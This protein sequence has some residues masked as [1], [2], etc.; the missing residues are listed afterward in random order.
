MAH[1]YRN[2]NQALE[3]SGQCYS[4]CLARKA[5][6]Y[7]L[8]VWLASVVG[9]LTLAWVLSASPRQEVLLKS[10]HAQTL[11]VFDELVAGEACA[12]SG[13]KSVHDGQACSH[14]KA[15]QSE[16]RAERKLNSPKDVI[17]CLLRKGAS[18]LHAALS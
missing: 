5:R 11:M 13:D 1:I 10:I 15:H 7:R 6:F 9:V 18:K 17:T 8:Q 12:M 16:R 3:A 2:S 4:T 14:G